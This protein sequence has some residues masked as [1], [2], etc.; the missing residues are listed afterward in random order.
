MKTRIGIG[1]VPVNVK[2]ILDAGEY[3][4]I[5]VRDTRNGLDVMQY[6]SQDALDRLIQDWRI[7]ND[8][9][10]EVCF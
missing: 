7:D 4:V 1:E 2:V 5:E 10:A 3:V 9:E 8:G 6:L